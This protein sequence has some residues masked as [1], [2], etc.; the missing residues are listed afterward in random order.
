M[1][2]NL[3]FYDVEDT[4]KAATE[5]RIDVLQENIK[6]DISEL[7]ELHEQSYR[8]LLDDLNLVEAKDLKQKIIK[9]FDEIGIGKDG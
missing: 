1:K 3:G 9:T 7:Q 6:R 5:R 4:R 8:D 2:D